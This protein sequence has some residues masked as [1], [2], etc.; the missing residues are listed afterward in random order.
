[1]EE[2]EKMTKEFS[3]GNDVELATEALERMAPLAYPFARPAAGSV[4]AVLFGAPLGE[5]DP[6]NG[7]EEARTR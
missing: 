3:M 4:G 1:M 5:P 7:D 2:C 6:H